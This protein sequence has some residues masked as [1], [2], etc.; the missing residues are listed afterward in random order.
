M[1][2]KGLKPRPARPSTEEAIRLGAET[3]PTLP[4]AVGRSPLAAED[5]STTLNL[6]LREGTVAALGRKAKAEGMTMKQ[7]VAHALVAFGV[8]IVPDDLEDRT[9][10]RGRRRS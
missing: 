6:R 8:E 4:P 10:R 5:R 2:T 9:P 3:E 1:M 7:V